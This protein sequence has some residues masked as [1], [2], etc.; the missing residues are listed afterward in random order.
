MEEIVCYCKSI[1]R[2]EIMEAALKGAV[3][4][5]QIRETTGACTG[6]QC[7]ELNPDGICCSRAIF[8]ILYSLKKGDTKSCGIGDD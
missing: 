5:S 6:N 4:L 3:T 1:T 2:K 7:K 8:D